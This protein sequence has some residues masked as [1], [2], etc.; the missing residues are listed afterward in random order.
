MSF[1]RPADILIGFRVWK[2]FAGSIPADGSR[3]VTLTSPLTS[4]F[5]AVSRYFRNVNRQRRGQSEVVSRT[6]QMWWGAQLRF[7]TFWLAQ[8]ARK[9]FLPPWLLCFH[10][11]YR[12]SRYL[13]CAP[14]RFVALRRQK[15]L[16][17]EERGCSVMAPQ[18]ERSV[19]TLTDGLHA[20]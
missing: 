2:H 4:Q 1:H 15:Y 18:L 7:A 10:R 17:L 6:A 5:S 19:V 20:L 3:D 13:S 16:L 9:E 11:S 12:C 14:A 8:L